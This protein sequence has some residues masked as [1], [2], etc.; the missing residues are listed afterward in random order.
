MNRTHRRLLRVGL[1][2]AVLCISLSP[3]ASLAYDAPIADQAGTT[4]IIFGDGDEGP[5]GSY[6]MLAMPS[7]TPHILLPGEVVYGDSDEGAID[8][9]P[10]LHT[11]LARSSQAPDLQHLPDLIFTDEMGGSPVDLSPFAGRSNIS[12]AELAGAE[13]T[14]T[15]DAGHIAYQFAF[16]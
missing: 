3:F 2:G 15:A 13:P 9:G 12:A 11:K 5:I 14:Q 1:A 16:E 7:T 10:A 8:A 6:P 4:N